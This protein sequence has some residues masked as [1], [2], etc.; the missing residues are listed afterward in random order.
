MGGRIIR[1]DGIPDTLGIPR[2]GLIKIGEKRMSASGKEYP[3]SLDYFKASGSYESLFHKAL[4]EK[5]NL[6]Q[7]IFPSDDAEQVCIERYEMR[8]NAGKLLAEG[9]G[10][11]FKVWNGNERIVL[12]VDKYPDLMEKL[13]AKYKSKW[14]ITLTLRFLVPAV[15]GVWGYWQLTTKG[16]ASSIPQIREA[17]DAFLE[18]NGRIQGVIFDL[19]VKFA[20]SSKPNDSSK[21]PVLTLIPNESEENIEKVKKWLTPIAQLE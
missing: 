1:G 14:V 17:Y 7:I 12:S 9:D 4:G 6:I 11:T 16:T 13:S 2:A 5:P 19:G 8:D 10:Q 3:T 18:R 20:K 15:K 21:F